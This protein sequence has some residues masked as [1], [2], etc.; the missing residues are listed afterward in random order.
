MTSS[1]SLRQNQIKPLLKHKED[2]WQLKEANR[3]QTNWMPTKPNVGCVWGQFAAISWL[4]SKKDTLVKKKTTTK[5][6][7]SKTIETQWVTTTTDS[8]KQASNQLNAK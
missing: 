8:S 6:I 3:P 7:R 5:P 4:S 2:P 1:K